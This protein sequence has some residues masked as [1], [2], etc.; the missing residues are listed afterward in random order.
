[1]G[2]EGDALCGSTWTPY[3]QRT[4]E[5]APPP[6]PTRQQSSGTVHPGSFCDTPGETGVTTK[7]TPMMCGIGSDGEYRWKSAN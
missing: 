7:G 5:Y 4:T 3:N 6:V 1:M 2:A